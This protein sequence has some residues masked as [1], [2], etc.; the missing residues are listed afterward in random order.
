MEN[1]K[2]TNKIRVK[3][4]EEFFYN[5]NK[6]GTFENKD[7]KISFIKVGIS[8]YITI[9]TAN[10]IY[11]HFLGVSIKDLQNL[12]KD[13]GLSRVWRFLEGHLYEIKNN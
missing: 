7:N 13:G 12:F 2:N 11:V 5:L 4:V 1:F 8:Y 10:E 9:E 6:Q 3:D